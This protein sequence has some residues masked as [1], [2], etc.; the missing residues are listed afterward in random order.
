[1]TVEPRVFAEDVASRFGMAWDYIS[2]WNERKD[3]PPHRIG[4]LWKSKISEVDDWVLQ[5]GAGPGGGDN[6]S[7]ERI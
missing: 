4:R 7:E 2:Q 6:E 5:G 3:L 1:M